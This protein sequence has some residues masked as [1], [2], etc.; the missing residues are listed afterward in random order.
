MVVEF[1]DTGYMAVSLSRCV[2]MAACTKLVGVMEV[3]SGWVQ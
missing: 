3:R 1:R 2:M